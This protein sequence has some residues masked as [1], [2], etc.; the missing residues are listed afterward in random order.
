MKTKIAALALTTLL[1][2]AAS[3]TRPEIKDG[4]TPAGP[5]DGAASISSPR[6]GVAPRACPAAPPSNG[7]GAI[8]GASVQCHADS[9]CTAG[10][11][12][13]CMSLG[14]GHALAVVS[15]TYDACVADA[16]CKGGELCICGSGTDRSGCRPA[17]CHDDADCG[18]KRCDDSEGGMTGTWGRYCHSRADKCGSSADCKDNE[19]CNY[20]GG[21]SRWECMARAPHPVG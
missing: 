13:R 21:K 1:V 16:E 4:V 12:G 18:G 14:G 3:C 2:T 19:V 5:G 9:E 11:N 15:C 7:A 17:N 6:V 10:K 8:A 20:V